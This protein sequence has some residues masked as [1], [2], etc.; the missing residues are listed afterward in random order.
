MVQAVLYCLAQQLHILG[1]NVELRGNAFVVA[2]IK[3]S[4]DQTMYV[5][6]Y[7][8][9]AEYKG[10]ARE[11][12]VPERRQKSD[13]PAPASSRPRQ[14]KPPATKITKSTSQAPAHVSSSD[15]LS[16]VTLSK[17][18]IL[19][20]SVEDIQNR[21][22]GSIPKN[23][24]ILE[25]VRSQTNVKA[26]QEMWTS[27]NV[28]SRLEAAE[29]G[30]AKLSSLV[31][32]LIGESTELQDAAQR[33]SS[34]KQEALPP[35]S[36]T[37]TQPLST[38]VIPPATPGQAVLANKAEIEAMQSRL[39]QMRADLD[40]LTKTF[41][42]AL[43]EIHS[44]PS[45][46]NTATPGQAGAQPATA[47]LAERVN[48]LEKRLKICC[49]TIGKKDGVIQDQI[50]SFQDQ[51]EYL[52]KQVGQMSEELASETNKHL[53]N[54]YCGGSHTTTT[55][56]QRVA[57]LGHFMKQWGPDVMYR[58]SPAVEVAV[59][60]GNV[61]LRYTPIRG[62][63][64][65]TCTTKPPG[66]P[67]TAKPAAHRPITI[68][69]ECRCLEG[70]RHSDLGGKLSASQNV[71]EIQVKDGL[72]KLLPKFLLAL[73]SGCSGTVVRVK[74][75][76]LEWVNS[77]KCVCIKLVLFVST[78]EITSCLLKS[79]IFHDRNL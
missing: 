43:A 33:R 75:V 12:E 2:P 56:A 50:N 21:V 3:E 69:A 22:Y 27:F 52:M 15:K 74:N 25:E 64:D 18:N 54:R 65:S 17:F 20:K 14:D 13:T 4:T 68:S 47:G 35:P 79:C 39:N 51:L 63:V 42:S 28:S 77:Y 76:L 16:L 59:G 55:A 61:G 40:G 78:R 58:V 62:A 37:A 11:A 5:R 7:F 57:R 66:M 72:A 41:N 30:I 19:E 48:E 73:A 23:E 24:D 53:C 49:D 9:D 10:P 34:K 45:A 8:I 60:P 1:K 32:D 26:I 46:T 70:V 71:F 6:E 36:A 44:A 29:E 38:V 31:E 67:D